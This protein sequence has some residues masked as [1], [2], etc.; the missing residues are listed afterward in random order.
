MLRDQIMRTN[1]HFQLYWSDVGNIQCDVQLMIPKVNTNIGIMGL[2]GNVLS[3]V[4]I[5]QKR[6]PKP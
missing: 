2:G 5:K 4:L 3:I 6:T 1:H